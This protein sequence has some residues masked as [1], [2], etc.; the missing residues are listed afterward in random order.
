M[1][2]IPGFPEN[3]SPPLPESPEPGSRTPL[4]QLREPEAA[5]SFL[6][7][8][9]PES[10]VGHPRGL[11][12]RAPCTTLTALALDDPSAA[13]RVPWRP[14]SHPLG[15]QPKASADLPHSCFSAPQW[16]PTAAGCKPLL[17]PPGPGLAPAPRRPSF[18]GPYPRPSL[19]APTP[20]TLLFIPS[21]NTNS[22]PPGALPS[23]GGPRG[24]LP[25]DATVSCGFLSAHLA[26]TV[27][28]LASWP[29]WPTG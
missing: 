9:L 26:H 8:A 17:C 12:P 20:R 23:P 5:T 7:L 19:P 10:L 24:P 2:S 11:F 15:G 13:S 25:C 27:L 21:C 1:H 18:S 6:S 4:P 16:L 14:A 3:A 22:H 29:T 28:P